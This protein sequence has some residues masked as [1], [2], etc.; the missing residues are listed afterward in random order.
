MK[1]DN[2]LL[3]DNSSIEL[4]KLKMNNMNHSNFQLLI[5]VITWVSKFQGISSKIQM[6]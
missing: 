5:P 6:T 3:I 1:K 2:T 4:K